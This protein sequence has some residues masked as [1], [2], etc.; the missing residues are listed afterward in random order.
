MHLERLL[1][2]TSVAIYGASENISPGRRIIEALDKMGFAGAVYPINPRYESV[3]GRRCYPAIDA[4]PKGVDAIVFCVNHTLVMEPYRAAAAHGFGAAVILD[5]GFAEKG[6]DGAAR[7]R[8]IQGITREAGMALCGPNCMGVLNPVFKS[9]LYTGV[10][11]DPTPL[12]GNVALITQSGSIAIGQL[13]DLRRYGFSHVISAGNEAATTTADYIDY[14]ADEPETKVI[15]TFTEAIRDPEKYVA[16]LDKAADRGKPVVVL[17][18]GKSDR[19]R[20][21]IT[22]HT[23]GLAGESKVF[24]QIL[25]RHRAIEVNDMDELTEVLAVC[26]GARW[27]KGPRVGVLTAS[28]GQ[29]EL[30]LD[31]ATEH[32]IDLPPLSKDGIAEASRVLGP[33]SGDGNPLDSWGDGKFQT[34]LPHGLKVLAAEPGLDAVVM[35][36]DTRDGQVMAPTQ[37]QTYLI[38]T[39]ETTDKPCYFMSTRSGLFRQDYVAQFR[40]AGLVQI[41]GTRQGLGAIRRLG[42]WMQGPPPARP[43]PAA[44]RGNLAALLKPGRKTVNEYDAKRLFA[45]LGLRTTRERRVDTAADAAAAARDIGWPVVLKVVADSIPHRSEHGL[46]AVGLRDEAALAAAFAA[47]Q[48]RLRGLGDVATGAAFL[49]QEMVG[50]GVEAFAGISS[51]PDFGPVLA[52][53]LGGIYVELFR[54]VSLRPAPLRAGEAEAMIAETKAA[55]L[56]AG[57][58]GAP[59]G[60]VAAL[61]DCLYRLADWAH[62]ERAHIQEVDLNPIKVL[63]AGQGIVVVDALI[64]PKQ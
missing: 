62:A 18:V 36:S 40:A 35:A 25:R 44:A 8:E 6:A 37:Y 30:I 59:A 46:V 13:T 33:I 5:A 21:A 14:L 15:A 19:T 3:L 22:G 52:F 20:A 64:V 34:N 51:D 7:Q 24:S 29:A 16:A 12:A 47:M 49:V 28:G 53:G 17:K 32:G 2:P 11:T 1:N 45:D 9:S 27:P 60:D 38:E 10:L 39:A 50:G 4:L 54:D 42:E 48:Q 58:R 23:G 63:P 57:F 55:T 31:L 26:Q 56:L 43:A 41:G 61:A